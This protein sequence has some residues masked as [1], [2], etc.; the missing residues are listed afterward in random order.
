MGV[1]NINSRPLN[2]YWLAYITPKKSKGFSVTYLS[3]LFRM[4]GSPLQV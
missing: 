2:D 3:S 4:V 1:A